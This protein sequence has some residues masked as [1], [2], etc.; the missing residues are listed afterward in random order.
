MAAQGEKVSEQ[1]LDALLKESAWIDERRRLL[2]RI[3]SLEQEVGFLS[4]EKGALEKV[5]G[6]G[7]GATSSRLHLKPV[8]G[9]VDWR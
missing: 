1:T 5:G 2:E 3:S 7:R 4:I 9:L 8:S 6:V